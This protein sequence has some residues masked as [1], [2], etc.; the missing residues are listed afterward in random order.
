MSGPWRTLTPLVTPLVL[1]LVLAPTLLAAAGA[2]L[3]RT[4]MLAPAPVA[5]PVA[6]LVLAPATSC[7]CL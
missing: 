1:V 5:A 2:V 3:Q 6:S 4:A 7:L